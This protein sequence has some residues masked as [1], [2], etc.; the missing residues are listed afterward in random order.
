MNFTGSRWFRA[1][2]EQRLL[3]GKFVPAPIMIHNDYVPPLRYT[4]VVLILRED[5]IRSNVMR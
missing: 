3:R 5:V 4:L 2:E 1:C